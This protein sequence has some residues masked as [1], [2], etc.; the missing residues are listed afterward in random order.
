MTHSAMSVAR[1]TEKKKGKAESD[2]NK[3]KRK[4]GMRLGQAHKEHL[5]RIAKTQLM[6]LYVAQL[7]GAGLQSQIE[8]G[9]KCDEE[10]RD[11]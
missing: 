4:K 3:E 2:W 8:Q 10:R 9:E 7:W 1:E 6:A 5:T 11:Q